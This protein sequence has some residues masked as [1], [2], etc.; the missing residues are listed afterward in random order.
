MKMMNEQRRIQLS[1]PKEERLFIG[2]EIQIHH[3]TKE[4]NQYLY[5]GKI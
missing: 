4:G 1:F 5:A 2:G 3:L